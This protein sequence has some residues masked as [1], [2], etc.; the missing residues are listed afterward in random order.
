M[1][2]GE[3]VIIKPGPAQLSVLRA[4]TQWVDQ[5]KSAACVGA[6]AYDVPR[7][8]RNLRFV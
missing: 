2:I 4:E 1:Q 3:I 5:V 7:I 6:Q 8:W